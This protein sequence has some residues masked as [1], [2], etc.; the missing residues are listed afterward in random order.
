MPVDKPHLFISGIH[1]VTFTNYQWLPLI[2]ITGSYDLV[3]KWF[4]VLQ[5]KGHSV[6][7]YVVMPNH[8]HVLIAF[9]HPS[10]SLNT[11]IGNGKRFIAYGILDRLKQAGR[12]D[13]LNKLSAGVT[14][15]DKNRGKLHQVFE[16]SFDIKECS[17]L[18]FINQKLDYIHNNPVAK[19]WSLAERTIDYMH[20]SA[21]FY[22]TG[23]Q[24][25]FNVTNFIEFID[26]DWNIS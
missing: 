9:N 21:L 26:R 15:S 6:V 24:S 22:E 5:S 20:S 18:K 17:T 16:G 4:D 2:E 11:I 14:T 8:L 12:T 19:K 23:V 10:Q 25:L 7:G 3:Y 1:F 13:I